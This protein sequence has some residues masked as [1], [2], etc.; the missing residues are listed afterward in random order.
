LQEK[1]ESDGPESQIVG[2]ELKDDEEVNGTKS[3]SKEPMLARYVRKHHAPDQIIGDK[4]DGTMTRNKLKCTCLLVEFEPRNVKD[5]LDNESWIEAMNE[6]IEQIEKNKTWTLV[7]RPK[8]KNVIGTKWVF[9]NKL[10]ED[11]Q[12][13]RN[14]ARLLCKGYSQ[15]E[16]F[17]YGGNFA[18]VARLEGV[19]TLLA[20]ATLRGFKVYQMDVKSAFLNE[21][22]DEEVY[23]EQPK[24]FVDPRKR[25]M[26]YKLHKAL[27]GLKQAPRVWYEGLHNYLIK[28]GFQRTNDNNSLYIKEGPNKK[29][30]LAEIFVDDTLFIGNGDL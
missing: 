28:I 24:G 17:D 8:D 15:E 29:I 18:P 22:L 30:V 25:D 1:T 19:R 12:V 13:S 9:R 10:N 21:I 2:P 4:S 26:A 7:P 27:Y 5:S 16:G 23:I 20:Y 3:N 6:E 14:K 11:G